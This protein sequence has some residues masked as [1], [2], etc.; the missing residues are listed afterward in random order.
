[1][2]EPSTKEELA[3]EIMDLLGLSLESLAR[4]T[5][6]D[7]QQLYNVF[8]TLKSG[9]ELPT[10]KPL[11]DILDEEINGKP[12]RDYTVGELARRVRE[13]GPFGLGIVP[14]IRRVW[15]TEIKPEL[16]RLIRGER[17]EK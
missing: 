3:E 15:R 13:E 5:K 4:M 8:K 10:D 16:R 14:E 12:I 1:M 9:G 17:K 11:G 7:L 2:A 6:E